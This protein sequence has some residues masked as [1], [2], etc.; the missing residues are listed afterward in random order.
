MLHK[1]TTKLVRSDDETQVAKAT[2]H[3][4]F[5]NCRPVVLTALSATVS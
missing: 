1:S 2:A 3:A 5:N 4:W